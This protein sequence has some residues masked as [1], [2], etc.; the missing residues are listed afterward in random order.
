MP[1]APHG[2]GDLLFFVKQLFFIAQVLPFAASAI[3]KMLTGRRD[4]VRRRCNHPL[5]D[6]N[7]A[8]IISLNATYSYYPTYAQVLADYNRRLA[9]TGPLQP[10]LKPYTEIFPDKALSEKLTVIE[11]VFAPDEMDALPGMVQA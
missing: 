5:D 1:N 2:L 7:W 11:F 8:P 3:P 9:G 6:P 10:A 4:A